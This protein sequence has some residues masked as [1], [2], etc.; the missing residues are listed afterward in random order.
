MPRTEKH[1]SNWGG[2]RPNSGPK[3]PHGNA[4]SQ[5]GVRLYP[6]QEAMVREWV[7]QFNLDGYSTAIRQMIERADRWRK[8]NVARKTKK[9]V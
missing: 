8:S 5:L 7:Q 3:T 9:E 1:S 4:K 2:A 6:V